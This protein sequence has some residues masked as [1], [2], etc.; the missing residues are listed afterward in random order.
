MQSRVAKRRNRETNSRLTLLHV[1]KCDAVIVHD[2]KWLWNCHR[3]FAAACQLLTLLHVV[4]CDAM[5]V[6]DDKMVM[7]LSS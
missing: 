2:D 5:I 4:K 1:V 3:D 6:H 7:E